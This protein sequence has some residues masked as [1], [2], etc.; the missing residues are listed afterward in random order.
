MSVRLWCPKVVYSG[1]SLIITRGICRSYTVAL[2][3]STF[4]VL[5]LLLVFQD[6]H[7]VWF[8]ETI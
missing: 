6:M 7:Y 8:K 2:C 3:R 1:S 5:L 4:R